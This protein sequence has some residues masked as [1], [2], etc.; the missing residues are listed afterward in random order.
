M[1]EPHALDGMS[2]DDRQQL[3][4]AVC[5]AVLERTRRVVSG[6]GVHGAVI[7]GEKPSRVLASAFI[8]PRLNEDGDDESSDIKIPA[9]G[10]DLR[11]RPAAGAL[12]VLPNLSVYVRALPTAAELFGRDGRLIPRADFN[13]AARQHAKDQISRR[14]SAEIPRGTPSGERAVRR[15]A[16]SRE[17]YIAMGVGVP[18]AARLPGGDDR[19]DAAVEEGVPPSQVLGGRLRIPDRLSRRYDIPQKWIRLRVDVPQLELP[20]PCDPDRWQALAA[21]HKTELLRSIR[22]AY[23]GLDRVADRS[24]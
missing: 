18:P 23:V 16:I 7:L 4:E 21:D 24:K 20:L 22:T 1:A 14:A 11:V 12:R 17:I 15:A 9:H 5:D 13:D 3:K 2:W 19:D 6:E 10:I 8:L